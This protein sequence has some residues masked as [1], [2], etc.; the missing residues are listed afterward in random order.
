MVEDQ[1]S[2]NLTLNHFLVNELFASHRYG[3]HFGHDSSLRTPNLIA[4]T[5]PR[6]PCWL[7]FAGEFIRIISQASH[8][9]REMSDFLLARANRERQRERS[10]Y[11]ATE[12]IC[13]SLWMWC[14][15]RI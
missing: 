13:S 7:G 2:G 4:R 5:N 14:I 9:E 11:T 3:L 1:D 12:L 6:P 8:R 10:S 15:S